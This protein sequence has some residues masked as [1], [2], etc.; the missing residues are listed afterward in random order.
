MVVIVCSGL[1]VA[2]DASLFTTHFRKAVGVTGNISKLSLSHRRFDVSTL[3]SLFG[4][5]RRI[6]VN[7]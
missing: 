6:E 7:G 4:V 5:E 3:V 2:M 1:F